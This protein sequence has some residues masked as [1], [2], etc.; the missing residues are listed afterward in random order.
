MCRWKDDIVEYIKLAGF[1]RYAPKIFNKHLSEISG[2]KWLAVRVNNEPIKDNNMRPF[3]QLV[4]ELYING[5][6]P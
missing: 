3:F 5:V 1:K 6:K 2:Q 4:Q